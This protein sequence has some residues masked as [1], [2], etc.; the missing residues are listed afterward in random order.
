M[1]TS[2]ATVS[3]AGDLGEKLTAIAKAGFDGIESMAATMQGE[4]FRMLPAIQ[5]APGTKLRQ[6]ATL[7]ATMDTPVLE[8]DG[9]VG[10]AQTEKQFVEII[11]RAPER[12]GGPVFKNF[13]AANAEKIFDAASTKSSAC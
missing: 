8:A 9:S 3:I 7:A 5:G 11:E 10:S 12:A 4:G 1:K 13:L 6:T 2:T